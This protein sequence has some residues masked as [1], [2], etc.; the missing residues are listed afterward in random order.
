[1]A[2]QNVET[3]A[4]SAGRRRLLL[5]LGGLAAFYAGSRWWLTRPAPLNFQPAPGLPGFRRLVDGPVSQAA[6]DPLIGL[7]RRAEP[8]PEIGDDLKP[9][10][11]PGDAAG[12]VPVAY[13]ADFRC[14]NCAELERLL[15]VHIEAGEIRLFRHEWPI[16]GPASVEAARAALA[17]AMQ[18]RAG[19]LDGGLTSSRLIVTAAYLRPP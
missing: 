11:F 16:L 14:P 2:S 17:A 13:F 3:P 10:L 12:R 7:D 5:A 9:L 1:M 18:G 15:R 4:K 19:A 6:F 8:L